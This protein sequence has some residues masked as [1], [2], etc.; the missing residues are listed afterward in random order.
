VYGHPEIASWLAGG[1]A[2]PDEPAGVDVN[3]AEANDTDELAAELAAMGD[4]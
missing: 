2:Q 4:D 3:A 1:Q